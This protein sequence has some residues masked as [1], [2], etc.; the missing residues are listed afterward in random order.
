[1]YGA[2]AKDVINDRLWGY[3]GNKVNVCVNVDL[4]ISI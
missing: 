3:Y 4:L 1:M 2:W